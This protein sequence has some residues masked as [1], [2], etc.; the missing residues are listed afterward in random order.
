[1]KT[2]AIIG[3]GLAI[4][5][6]GAARAAVEEPKYQVTGHVGAVEI[7][8]YGPRLA[9]EAS[10]GGTEEQARNAGFRKVAGYIFGGN[11]AKRSIAM[12]A[13]VAQAAS[14]KIAMTAP[15]AQAAGAGG[16][17][18]VQFVMPAQY[19]R[20]TLPAPTDPAVR[21]VDLPAQ[22]Y[23]VLRFSGSTSAKAVAAKT[24]ALKAALAQPG[25]GWRATGAPVAWFYDP[26]WTL[27]G[28]RR[29]EVAVPVA[30]N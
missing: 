4:V 27:P 5:G 20:E 1:M 28:F 18:T 13:P 2:A 26:P 8:H 14:Q 6:A 24:L 15:V 12:T 10:S 19:T 9:A 11:V 3:A 30:R 23:A 21:I 29:N 16:T 17:W 22:D 25:A 7:R